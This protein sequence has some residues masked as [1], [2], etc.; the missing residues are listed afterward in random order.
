MKKK[1]IQI[2]FHLHFIRQQQITTNMF[3]NSPD[4]I[5]IDDFE[6]FRELLQVLDPSPKLRFYHSFIS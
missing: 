3:L 1:N 5:C 4:L 6:A 2:K